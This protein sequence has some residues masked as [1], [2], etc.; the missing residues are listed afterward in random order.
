M[1]RPPNQP[2]RLIFDLIDTALLLACCWLIWNTI[3]NPSPAGH[4]V[5]FVAI[6]TAFA[7]FFAARLWRHRVAGRRRNS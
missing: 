1:D 5:I 6:Y 4:G 7:V 3:H 2:A